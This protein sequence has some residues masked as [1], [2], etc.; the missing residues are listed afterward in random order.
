MKR[1]QMVT[2]LLILSIFLS[3]ITILAQT[4]SHQKAAVEYL[5]AQKSIET[6][7]NGVM[8]MFETKIEQNPKLSQLRDIMIKWVKKYFTWEILSPAYIKA[9][10]DTFSEAELRE[11]T[12]FYLTPVGQKMLEKN[13]ELI[14]KSSDVTMDIFKKYKPELDKMFVER[15]KEIES[16]KK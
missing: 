14:R 12:T 6:T 7:Q 15:I 13:T 2:L 10:M 4:S 16:K 9:T 3:S 5:K 11:I 1:Y 8:L